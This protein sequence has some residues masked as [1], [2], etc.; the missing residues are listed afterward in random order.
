MFWEG[1]L[2]ADWRTEPETEIWARRDEW[3]GPKSAHVKEGTHR[4]P[5]SVISHMTEQREQE[6]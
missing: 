1:I 5:Y 2:V 4:W 6:E 3:V